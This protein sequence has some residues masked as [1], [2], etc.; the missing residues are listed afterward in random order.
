MI[1]KDL[2]ALT[3][4]SDLEN[5]KPLKANEAFLV[6]E[7]SHLERLQARNRKDDMRAALSHQGEHLGAVWTAINKERKPRDL[8]YHLKYQAQ[9]HPDSDA[10][11]REW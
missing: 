10:T 3:N 4:I 1:E 11:Q 2:K 8:L 5:N 7:L 6:N 9:T